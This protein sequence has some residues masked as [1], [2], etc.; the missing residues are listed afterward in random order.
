MMYNYI[1]LRFYDKNNHFHHIYYYECHS[2]CQI[3]HD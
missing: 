3:K 2:V 1:F